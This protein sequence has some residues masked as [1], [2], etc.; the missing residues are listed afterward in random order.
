MKIG[1]CK[2][3]PTETCVGYVHNAFMPASHIIPELYGFY[4]PLRYAVVDSLAHGIKDLKTGEIVMEVTS[5]DYA[6]FLCDKL[7]R[8]EKLEDLQNRSSPDL[9]FFEWASALYN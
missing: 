5:A 9:E 4:W 1:G 6:Y 7:N 3:E 2:K 8:C